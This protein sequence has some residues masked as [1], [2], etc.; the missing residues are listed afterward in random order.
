MTD[1]SLPHLLAVSG[2]CLLA[3]VVLMT[4]TALV[5]HRLGKVSVVDTSWGLGFV[6]VAAVVVLAATVAVTVTVARAAS[7]TTAPRTAVT[8]PPS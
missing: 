4:V 6:V 3:V 8:S 5:G 1:V 2:W 7:A